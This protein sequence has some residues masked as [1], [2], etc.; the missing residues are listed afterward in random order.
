MAPPSDIATQGLA[1]IKQWFA[2][3]NRQQR[4]AVDRVRVCFVG[5]GGAGKTTLAKLLTDGVSATCA[6]VQGAQPMCEW[7]GAQVDAWIRAAPNGATPAEGRFLEQLANALINLAP[8]GQ[9]LVHD[10]SKWD[11][12]M[13]LNSTRNTFTDA[14]VK[15]WWPRFRDRLEN[16]ER[17]GYA[18]TIGIDISEMRLLA[19]MGQD[20]IIVEMMDFSGQ[21]DYYSTHAMFLAMQNVL[22]VLVSKAA[23]KNSA[24]GS[25]IEEALYWLSYLRSSASRLRRRNVGNAE[26]DAAARVLLAETHTDKI[27]ARYTP[28]GLLHILGE[29]M[30]KLGEAETDPPSLVRS[31]VCA[32]RYD[33]HDKADKA[34]S[35][36]I[37]SIEQQVT[38]SVLAL[39]RS[40]PRCIQYFHQQP[41]LSASPSRGHRFPL[42]V[43]SMDVRSRRLRLERSAGHRRRA[44]SSQEGAD[45]P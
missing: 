39:F 27:D 3:R 45:S 24:P 5:Y 12:A 6:A 14:E 17:K 25:Q 18:S 22:Y 41:L 19:G 21:M 28:D 20:G 9:Y 26:D 1:R 43:W 44:E 29:R 13:V 36:I 40:V 31:L 23:A 38:L 11:I 34:R 32:P 10:I 35:V 2:D 33:D 4:R 8:D 16:H 30:D 42:G 37:R 15:R 7:N